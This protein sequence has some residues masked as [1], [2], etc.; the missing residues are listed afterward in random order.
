M[1]LLENLFEH[2]EKFRISKDLGFILEDPLEE[3]PDCYQ[4]WVKLAKNL[5][6]LVE[7]GQFRKEAEQLPE[8]NIDQLQGYKEQRLAHLALAVI[9]MGY[10]WQDKNTKEVLPRNI[11]VPFWNLSEKL[12]LP[13]IMVYADC[14]LANWKK[15]DPLGSMTYD[16]MDTLF[17]F[18]G[19]DC[20]KGFFLVSLLVEKAAASAIKIIPD[21]F[22][23]ISENDLESLKENLRSVA[24]SV[25]EAYKVFHLVHEH[26]NPNDFFNILRIYLSGWKN[27]KL[28]PKGLVY[29][30]VS[31][32]PKEFAG[33][34]AA[35]SS[36]MQCFDALLGIQHI[37]ANDEK[38]AKYLEEMRSY[39]PSPHKNFLETI[40]SS[41]SVRDFVISSGDTQ[42]KKIY[43]ECIDALVLLRNYH[44]QVVAKYIINPSNNQDNTN[45][46]PSSDDEVKGTGGTN[47][48][49]FLKSVRNTTK[50]ALINVS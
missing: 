13:P 6:S 18:P 16:N 42:L 19:G 50:E 17:A 37:T 14:V 48:M 32:T 2:P 44:L 3:L 15:K 4:V 12:G 30:G 7:K 28:L 41:P 38:S 34:S 45:G 25:H 35:Q 43:N 8:L 29:E 24:F 23:A 36:I 11:A 21:I 10:V 20:S 40:A 49:F 31:E 39:M 33:G 26:V 47:L 46:V 1:A 9:T 27:N 5:P 22:E